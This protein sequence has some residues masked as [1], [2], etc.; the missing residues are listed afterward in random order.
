MRYGVRA[1]IGLATAAAVLSTACSD[2]TT[3]PSATSRVFADTSSS[4]ARLLG[5]LL[6]TLTG[7]VGNLLATPVHRSTPLASDVSWTFTASPYGSRSSNSAVG[8]SIYVPPGAVDRNVTI[9]VTALKGSAV[10]YRFEPHMEFDRKVVLTQSL[11]GLN[12]GLLGTGLLNLSPFKGAHFEGDTPSYNGDG[13]ALVTEVVSA[14]LN[15]FS[16]T[17]SFSVDHFSGWIVASG[18]DSSSDSRDGF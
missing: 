14:V 15:L 9:R 13:Q 12:Y 16:N 10:A 2:S 8:L 5:G 4:N 17:T 18:Y 11:H 6:G 3:S 7:T 1:L